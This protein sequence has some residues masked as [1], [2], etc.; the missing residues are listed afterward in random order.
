[1]KVNGFPFIY[2][3]AANLEVEAIAF[4]QRPEAEILKL[5]GFPALKTPVEKAGV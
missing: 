3:R 2:I 5:L 4:H 1:L